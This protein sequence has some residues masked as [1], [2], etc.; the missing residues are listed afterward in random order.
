[1]I[2]PLLRK[3]L[4]REDLSEQDMEQAMLYIF[5]TNN[6]SQTSSFLSLL[7]AKGETA[8]EIV[9]MVKHMQ[10]TMQSVPMNEVVVD[11][12]GTG[13]DCFNTMNISTAAALL[14]ASCGVK[15]VK[16]GNH[17]VSSQCGSADLL[18]AL[19]LDI[20]QNAQAVKQSIDASNFGFCYAPNYHPEF[21]KIKLLRKRLGIPTIFNLLGPLLNPAKAKIMLVGVAKKQQMEIFADVLLRL[22]VEK[23]FVF[24][25]E[26]MDELTT[27]G[28][29]EV[30]EISP[31]GKSYGFI[32][33][34]HY[35]FETCHISAL[36]G[37]SPSD[38]AK[39]IQEIFL[40]QH[41]AVADTVILNAAVAC[42]LY[43][44]APSIEEGVLLA[45]EVIARGRA[46]DLL[47]KLR[48]SSIQ[49]ASHGNY[50]R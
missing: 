1:M 18:Q 9:T 32:D 28:I 22:G 26:G 49:E 19:G 37:G 3:L 24:H 44:K 12:V 42:Y 36:Q 50:S 40:G 17:A 20:Y 41:S 38:N 33:P 16:H 23:G 8:V 27:A 14:A 25:C 7:A 39:I 5:N 13:G 2:T 11:I 34:S 48:Q 15:I 4:V 47:T 30:V 46:I 31:Y 6:P 21:K 10:S 35:G 45:K 43:G 29:T